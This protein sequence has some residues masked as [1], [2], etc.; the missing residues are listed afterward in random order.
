MA[1]P[2]LNDDWETTADQGRS[3]PS[4]ASISGRGTSGSAARRQQKQHSGAAVAM[5]QAQLSAAV[6]LTSQAVETAARGGIWTGSRASKRSQ[7]TLT[8]AVIL[9]QHNCVHEQGR[10]SLTTSYNRMLVILRC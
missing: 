9:T 3:P 2:E 6:G 10:C 5:E 8:G 4:R 1:E 7:R